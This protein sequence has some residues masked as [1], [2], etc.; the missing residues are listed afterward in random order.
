MHQRLVFM[1][2]LLLSDS[3]KHR[4]KLDFEQS[5]YAAYDSKIA[6]ASKHLGRGYKPRPA[7][8]SIQDCLFKFT[9]ATDSIKCKYF[10]ML[11]ARWFCASCN[12]NMSN[13]CAK[14]VIPYHP[15][16]KKICPI[17]SAPLKSIGIAN[18][19]KPFWERI[20]KFFAYPAK[21]D[22]LIYMGVLSVCVAMAYSIPIANVVVLIITFF[23][24][25]KY[26]CQCLSHTARGNLSPPD[27]LAR[28]D[29]E[30]ENISLKQ[31]AI[32]IFIIQ[33][34]SFAFNANVFMG[35]CATFFSL[36]SIP[37]ITMLLAMTG[38]FL[39]AINPIKAI[40]IM[41]GMGKSYL[42]LYVFLYT[43]TYK[44]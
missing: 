16:N 20:P 18:S 17:C 11:P 40:Q 10:P 23:G 25:L 2:F 36:L 37:A 42:I 3:K 27:V 9:M 34:N 21:L 8:V 5:I 13:E 15:D 33:I 35:F 28:N 43:K 22:A 6:G 39:N 12:V 29:K 1:L 7:W 32:F 4:N 26:A 44:K 31:Y 14:A 30:Y 41:F 24:I 38:S 19:I